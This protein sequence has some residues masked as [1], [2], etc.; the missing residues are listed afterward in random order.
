M[1]KEIKNKELE[2]I[3]NDVNKN[4][5]TKLL[6]GGDE[7]PPYVEICGGDAKFHGEFWK[8]ACKMEEFKTLF[9]YLDKNNYKCH[10]D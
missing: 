9:N 1:E 2:G 4:L 5:R 10:F 6:M 7:T 8:S 3:I